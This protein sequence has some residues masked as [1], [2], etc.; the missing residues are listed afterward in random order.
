MKKIQDDLLANKVHSFLNY[1]KL[2]LKKGSVLLTC[3]QMATLSDT[4]VLFLLGST[5]C[6]AGE[7]S[8]RAGPAERKTW[9]LLLTVRHKT[10]L[11]SP[12]KRSFMTLHEA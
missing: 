5:D 3:V 12:I 8:A 2:L 10:F 1:K 11:L 7:A 6:R 4:N 9:F